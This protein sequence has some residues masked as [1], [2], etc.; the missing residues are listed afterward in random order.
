MYYKLLILFMCFGLL[1][2][3]AHAGEKYTITGDVSFQYDGD[4]YVY[5]QEQNGLNSKDRVMNYHNHSASL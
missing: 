2:N 3:V 1:F 5:V 4:I